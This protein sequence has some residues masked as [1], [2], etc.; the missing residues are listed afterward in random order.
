M[1]PGFTQYLRYSS[2]Y[3]VLILT[4]FS[5][6]GGGLLSIEGLCVVNIVYN[7]HFP[8]KSGVVSSQ[9]LP[10]MHRYCV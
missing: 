1:I 10:V 6:N 5:L 9:V 7:D 3:T 4:D 2:Y 8:E